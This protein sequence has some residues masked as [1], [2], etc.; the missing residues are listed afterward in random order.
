MPKPS[1]A[2]EL[3]A[4]VAVALGLLLCACSP[5]TPEQEAQE[6]LRAAAAAADSA[7]S[8]FGDSLLSPAALAQAQEGT[9][10][11]YRD[12]ATRLSIHYMLEG[13]EKANAPEPRRWIA[14]AAATGASLAI[15]NYVLVLSDSGS[16]AD[17][18]E[19]RAQIAR[20]KT[21][22]AS[23]IAAAKAKNLRDAKIE[24]LE[25]IRD[26]ERD[27]AHGACGR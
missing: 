14:L 26:Q 21:L 22:Y 7:T 3:F 24:A 9:L 12:E 13:S 19:A 23:E 27:M 11:G 18:A 10:R 17:C 16:P 15:E 5:K 6:A 4:P 2:L 8:P 25:R 1:L 20:A